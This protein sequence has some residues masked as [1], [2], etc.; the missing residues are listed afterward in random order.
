MAQQKRKQQ[1]QQQRS[2][3]GGLKPF[4]IALAVIAVAGI[5]W[6]AY[7]AMGSGGAVTAPI[8][9][10]ELEAAELTAQAQ[11]VVHGEVDAPVQVTVFSDFT[12]PGCQA[13]TT[14]IEP[15]LR[16]QHIEAGNVRFVYFDFP[17][18]GANHP[19]G[20]VAARAARCAGD[21]GRF[22]E[23]HDRLFARQSQWSFARG[24]PIN[25]MI[26]YAGELGLDV[27]AFEDCLESDRHADVVSANRLLGERLGVGATPTVFIGTNPIAQWNDWNAVEAAILRELPVRDLVTDTAR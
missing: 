13:F 1:Q 7:S 8:D 24:A 27:G 3:G 6:I 16:T 11:P 12:C 22:W 26:Q 25:E 5:G 9:L 19:H 18:G 2:G 15:R 20:F 4:Y 17:L 21:Q 10:G 23:Y 14:N